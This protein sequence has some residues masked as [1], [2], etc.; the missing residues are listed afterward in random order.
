MVRRSKTADVAKVT[1]AIARARGTDD[2]SVAR[3]AKPNGSEPAS[4]GIDEVARDGIRLSF[5]MHDV[6]RMRRSAY[7]QFMKPLGITRAQWWVLAHLSRHDGMMQTQLADVLEV[8]KASLGDVIESLESG[9]WVDRRPDPTDK[10]AKRVYLTKPAQGL[11]KRMT[12]LEVEFNDRIFADL[13]LTE[14]A[15]LFNSLVKIKHA[16]AKL[17]AEPLGGADSN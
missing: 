7:D 10:R 12:S 13:P 3:M 1:K 9:G 11:I 14:R 15:A 17:S 8:G 16:I 4:A 5:L 6:S 2:V